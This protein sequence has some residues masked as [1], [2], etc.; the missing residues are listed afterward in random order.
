MA[1]PAGPITFRCPLAV[2]STCPPARCTA[3]T[4]SLASLDRQ[5]FGGCLFLQRHQRPQHPRTRQGLIVDSARSARKPQTTLPRR[6]ARPVGQ[7]TRPADLPFGPRWVRAPAVPH[8]RQ[9]SP[10]VTDGSDEPQVIDPS[11]HAVGMT[12]VGDSDCGPESHRSN[13]RRPCELV[14][15]LHSAA[16]AE[17]R[18]VALSNPVC[19]AG[20]PMGHHHHPNRHRWCRY[21]PASLCRARTAGWSGHRVLA[22]LVIASWLDRDVLWRGKPCLMSQV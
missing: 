21:D 17:G 12:R 22:V 4:I 2:R 16:E 3:A 8:G 14:G 5:R 19:P 11:A 9:R 6:G 1:A 20:G 13:V 18:P 10:A 7:R 15:C